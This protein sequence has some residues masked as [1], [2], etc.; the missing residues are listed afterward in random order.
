MWYFQPST[1]SAS[2]AVE[3]EHKILVEEP[4]QQTVVADF[5]NALQ[6]L[7][8]LVEELEKGELSLEHSLRRFERGVELTRTC[9]KALREAEQ[10]VSILLERDADSEPEPFDRGN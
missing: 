5:E 7:E 3:T 8:K 1:R 4:Q 10:K 2:D 9:Q 6:E